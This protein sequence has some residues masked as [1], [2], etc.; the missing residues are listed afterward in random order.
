MSLFWKGVHSEGAHGAVH[1]L[2]RRDLPVI[3]RVQVGMDKITLSYGSGGQLTHEL[4]ADV[5]ASAFK[6]PHLDEMDD[7]AILDLPR[8]EYALTTDSYVVDPIF[9]PGG[10]IGKLAICGTVND[11]ASCAAEPKYITAGF[12]LEEGLPFETLR[13]IVSSMAKEA[14]RAHVKIVAGDTKVVP[15]GKADKVFINTA[16]L[17]VVRKRLKI[18]GIKPGDKILINGPVGQHGLSILL[19]RERFSYH[20]GIKSDCNSLWSIVELL[21][22]AEIDIRFMRDP[23]RGGISATS[24][25]IASQS[26]YAFLLEEARIPVSVSCRH[27]AEILGL[28]LLDIAN[29]GK[30]LFFVSPQDAGRALKIMKTHPQG[31]GSEMIG[32]V[33]ALRDAKVY[34]KTSIGGQK[35]LGSPMTEP[36][37]RIC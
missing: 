20:A 33:L 30:M 18:S 15:R 3:F 35:I 14:R 4:I 26:G 25:E 31:R 28:E 16:G 5:F 29:E 22:Q 1:G 6:N 19:S 13:K 9:F 32:E 8:S 11:L 2:P 23:T 7:S 37:P 17:G 36:I 12:I 27:L 21:L 24:N 34:L 10:D